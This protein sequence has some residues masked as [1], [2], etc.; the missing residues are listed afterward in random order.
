[1]RAA[2]DRLCAIRPPAAGELPGGRTLARLCA[3]RDWVADLGARAIEDASVHDLL[4]HVVDQIHAVCDGIGQE[5]FGYSVA[6][7]VPVMQ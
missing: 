3:L 6:T 1:V 2:H 5:L 4:T 7:A